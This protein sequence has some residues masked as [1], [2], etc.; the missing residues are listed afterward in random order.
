VGAIFAAL[1]RCHSVFFLLHNGGNSLILG[2]LTVVGERTFSDET[3]FDYEAP[4]ADDC[5]FVTELMFLACFSNVR[6]EL[7]WVAKPNTRK[8]STTT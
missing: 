8:A 3:L 2:P 7:S 5:H 4:F 6:A 1:K